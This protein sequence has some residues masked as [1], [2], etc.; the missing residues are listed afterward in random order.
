M[1]TSPDPTLDLA[2]LASQTLQDVIDVTNSARRALGK[3]RFITM[4][5]GAEFMRVIFGDDH[6]EVAA[7]GGY[8]CQACLTQRK[9][10]YH[11]TKAIGCAALSG[12]FCANCGEAYDTA[13]MAGLLTFVD[14]SN[15]DGSFVLNTRMPTGNI[16]NMLSAIKLTNAIRVGEIAVTKEDAKK[17][18]SIGAAIKNMITSDNER[19]FRLMDMLRAVQ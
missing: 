16:S 15:P 8:Y 10:D 18:G 11:W 7:G 19:Y 17:A 3:V 6:T 12:W 13:R 2:V 4:T 1:P 5:K 9:Y 14:K